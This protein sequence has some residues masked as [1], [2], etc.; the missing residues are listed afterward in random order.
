MNKK[1][2]WVMLA[3]LLIAFMMLPAVSSKTV[4]AE[5][6]NRTESK[7]WNGWV[8]RGGHRYYYRNGKPVTGGWHQINGV[9]CY[10][11]KY[12]RAVKGWSRE[13]NSRSI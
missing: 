5:Q 2:N 13:K 6:N 9:S 1:R 7:I 8:T 4:H 3:V 12:G 11:D 10:F